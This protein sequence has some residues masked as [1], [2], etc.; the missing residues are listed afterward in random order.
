MYTHT[1]GYKSVSSISAESV[2]ARGSRDR[3]LRGGVS[4]SGAKA[5]NLAAH[6]RSGERMDEWMD[7][8]TDGRARR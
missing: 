6:G 8:Q 1:Y 5:V 2:T 7:G 4:I 3:Q